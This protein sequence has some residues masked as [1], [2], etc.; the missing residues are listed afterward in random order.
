MLQA[1]YCDHFSRSCHDTITNVGVLCQRKYVEVLRFPKLLKRM[2][3][4]HYS[5]LV[6][7]NALSSGLFIF[8]FYFHLGS[9]RSFPSVVQPFI[10]RCPYSLLR[11]YVTLLLLH[12][13][14]AHTKSPSVTPVAASCGIV[15]CFPP[16]LRP[17]SLFLPV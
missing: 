8:S 13:V 2:I 9:L 5:M 10:T 12:S 7:A 17:T 11:N 16:Q 14:C 6:T 15:A 3:S 4:C 1:L